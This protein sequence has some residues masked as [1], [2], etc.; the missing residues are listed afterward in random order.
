MQSPELLLAPSAVPTA[1]PP[2]NPKCILKRKGRRGEDQEAG[3]DLKCKMP[4]RY[5]ALAAAAEEGGAAV[6]WLWL[7]VGGLQS[8]EATRHSSRGGSKRRRSAPTAEGQEK[9]RP[10][11]RRRAPRLVASARAPHNRCTGRCPHHQHGGH[12]TW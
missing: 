4:A 11:D 2:P 8:A 1:P 3:K 9:Y 7:R 5:L 6:C 12:R 10:R